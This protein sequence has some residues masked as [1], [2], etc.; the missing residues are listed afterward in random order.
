MPKLI[1]CTVA[2]IILV[3]PNRI[4]AEAAVNGSALDPKLYQ[5]LRGTNGSERNRRGGKKCIEFYIHFAYDHHFCR[6]PLRCHIHS[7]SIASSSR[8]GSRTDANVSIFPLPLGRV[9]RLEQ[10][11]QTQRESEFVQ[12]LSISTYIYYFIFSS[13]YTRSH[14]LFYSPPVLFFFRFILSHFSS[15]GFLP[16]I[17]PLC[18]FS[19]QIRSICRC[20]MGRCSGKRS[21]LAFSGILFNALDERARES[22]ALPEYIKK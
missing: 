18:V 8:R 16:I 14:Q 13:L 10:N 20:K 7:H 9:G 21:E 1:L 2:S 4:D 15:V 5:R 19:F 6:L 12:M 17:L 11:R 22:P 3:G